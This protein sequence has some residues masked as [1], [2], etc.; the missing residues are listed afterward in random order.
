MSEDEKDGKPEK[1]FFVSRCLAFL[2]D[3]VIVLFLSSLIAT[4]FVDTS[5]M[6]TLR[7]QSMNIVEK[8]QKNQITDQEYLVEIS[9]LEYMMARSTELVTIIMI[10]ISVLDFVVLPLYNKGQTI[11]KKIFKLKITSDTGELTA[12]QLLFRALIANF[13]LL[14]IISILFIMFAG[15]DVYMNCVGL[16]NFIQY[17]ITFASIIMIAFGKEGLAV[18]DKLV[19]TKVVKVN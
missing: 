6:V 10:L 1:P 16:F 18:H 9:N 5:K 12:N 4:P 8:Y 17:I 13:L 11:G 15:R 2:I 7:E 3:M 14:N 19:H